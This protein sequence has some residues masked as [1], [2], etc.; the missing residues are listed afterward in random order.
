MLSF[1]M[2]MSIRG[3]NQ[4]DNW[5]KLNENLKARSIDVPVQL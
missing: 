4:S 1:I 5:L 3:D 2:A